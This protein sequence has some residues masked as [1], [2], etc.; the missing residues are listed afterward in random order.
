MSLVPWVYVL[1]VV[2]QLGKNVNTKK[3]NASIVSKNEVGNKVLEM[4]GEVLVKSTVE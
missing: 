3:K 4:T 1:V 2:V